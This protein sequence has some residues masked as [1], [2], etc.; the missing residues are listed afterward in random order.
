MDEAIYCASLV[1]IDQNPKILV[2]YV[3]LVF[4]IGKKV[5]VELKLRNGQQIL[6]NTNDHTAV[7]NWPI[8]HEVYAGKSPIPRAN[9]FLV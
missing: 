9:G 4:V 5:E 3:A 1:Q 2:F 8:K 6:L 7:S